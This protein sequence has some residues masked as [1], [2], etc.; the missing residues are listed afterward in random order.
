[1]EANATNA[2][3][4]TAAKPVATKSNSLS[5]STPEQ[6]ISTT[7]NKSISNMKLVIFFFGIISVVCIVAAFG[8]AYQSYEQAQSRAY[9]VTDMGTLYANSNTTNDPRSRKVEVESHVRTFVQNMFGFDEGNYKEHVE[10]GLHLIGN[11]GNSILAQYNQ[12]ELYSSL[13]KNNMTVSV[14]VDSIWVDVKAKPFRARLFARQQF[15]N[16]ASSEQF[17]LRADMTLRDVSRTSKNVHGLKI[18]N[19]NIFQNGKLE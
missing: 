1:M 12:I 19:W 13:V 7:F 18:E 2:N 14:F 8:F 10:K 5:M 17:L 3:L 6:K 4:K 16:S 9:V 15:E 11:D